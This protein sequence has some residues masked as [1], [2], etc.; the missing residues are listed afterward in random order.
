MSRNALIYF[1]KAPVVGRV[2][3]RLAQSIGDDY[4]ATLYRMM[5]RHLLC[6]KLPQDTDVIIAY[7]D[8]LHA[9]LPTYVKRKQF[10]FQSSGDLG[11]RMYDAF[12]N[13]FSQNYQRVILVGSD[14]PD[15]TEEILQKALTLLYKN[16]A[17]LSPTRDGG[18]YLIGFQADS[19]CHKPF[20]GIT[21]S[22]ED[23]YEKTLAKMHHLK[24]AKTKM[25]RDIDTLDDL[26]AFASKSSDTPLSYYAQSLLNIL[27]RISVIIPVFH[28][29]ET[30]LKTITHLRTNAH[31]KNYEIIVVDTHEKTTV[32]R[33]CLEE[34]RLAFAPKGRASQM[35]EGARIAQGDVVLFLHADTL[36]PHHWDTL[37]LQALDVKKVGAFSFGINDPHIALSFIETMANFRSFITKIPYGDQA[38]FFETTFF[39]ELGGYAQIPLME[40]VEIMRRL[41]KQGHKVALLKPKVLTSSRR[42]HKE[43]IV[44]TTLRNRI[45]SFLYWIGVEPKHLIKHYKPHQN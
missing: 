37:T 43:G 40:D 13:V 18:Y 22:K 11:E 3:T 31:L 9:H 19:F 41:K 33:L 44:Y 21:Y 34:V 20:Q 5:C 4:A 10:F 6:V 28:E 27:P 35:N 42:W 12:Q 24:V 30:L 38:H 29:D 39:R 1:M 25:L 8:N 15:I 7:D 16:N 32:N 14:I 26:R 36:V 2:K 23:V 45:V 17:V